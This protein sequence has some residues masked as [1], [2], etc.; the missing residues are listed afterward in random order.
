MQKAHAFYAGQEYH[1][2]VKTHLQYG[3]YGQEDIEAECIKGS[4][5]YWSS[6]A[7]NQ[8][9]ITPTSHLAIN[10][11]AEYMSLKKISAEES[12]AILK[13]GS[14]AQLDQFET[15]FSKAELISNQEGKLQYKLVI[16][17]DKIVYYH[18]NKQLHYIEYVEYSY[19]DQGEQINVQVSFNYRTELTF[20]DRKALAVDTY[21]KE[22]IKGIIGVKA[23]SNYIIKEVN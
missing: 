19:A 18:I 15:Y 6:S 7:G 11:N 17:T 14:M 4:E 3:Q 22:E 9:L 1:M 23:Y 12:A 21:I 8:V 20:E 10:D 2:Y 13:Q 16:G 5:G